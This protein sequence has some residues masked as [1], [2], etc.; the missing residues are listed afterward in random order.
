MRVSQIAQ[1]TD[2]A[3]RGC[4]MINQLVARNP[5]VAAWRE[6]SRRC[7]EIHAELA[8]ESGNVDEARQIAQQVLDSIRGT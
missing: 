3:N 8:A 4:E 2:A 6:N 7:L 1:A 5:T